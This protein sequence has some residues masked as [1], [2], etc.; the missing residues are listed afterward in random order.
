MV[1]SVK[2]LLRARG[3][4]SVELFLLQTGV[5]ISTLGFLDRWTKFTPESKYDKRPK[6]VFYPE[7]VTGPV[8]SNTL[9][10]LHVPLSLTLS[11]TSDFLYK[12]FH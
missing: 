8:S 5:I 2:F 11:Y 10:F 7:F 6:K 4:E 12:V 3:K 9:H 1:A